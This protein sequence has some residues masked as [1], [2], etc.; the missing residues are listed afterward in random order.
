M[1]AAVAA[2]AAAAFGGL[3]ASSISCDRCAATG[4]D[5]ESQTAF[6]SRL[7]ERGFESF[8]YTS[9]PHKDRKGWRG[10]GLRTDGP[11]DP[12]GSAGADS[13]AA[14]NGSPRPESGE[15]R[16]SGGAEGQKAAAGADSCSADEKGA[17]AGKSEGVADRADSSGPGIG[18]QG[19]NHHS[20]ATNRTNY[21]QLSAPSAP[22]PEGGRE[23]E[24]EAALTE[25]GNPPDERPASGSGDGL[26]PLRDE[27]EV[28][29][30]QRLRREGY[31]TAEARALV[32]AAREG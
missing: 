7:T 4:E 16:V 10:L 23:T 28:Q 3:S 1:V 8:R 22:A 26:G 5:K 20:R 21:P 11:D 18:G 31:Y 25:P 14:G 27:V 2:A 12:A 24:I 30:L 9:G 19:P 32:V 17:F 13:S 6:G 29:H 15:N